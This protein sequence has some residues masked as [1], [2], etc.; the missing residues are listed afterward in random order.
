MTMGTAIYLL[1]LHNPVEAAELSATLA[2]VTGGGSFSAWP[3]I[4]GR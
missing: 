2:V 1:S 4:P 3:R